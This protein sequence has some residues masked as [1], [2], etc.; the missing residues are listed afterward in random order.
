MT[1]YLT[2]HVDFAFLDEKK[3]S[4]A[5]IVLIWA[6]LYQWNF[7]A[8]N[9]IS[10]A[11][12]TVWRILSWKLPSLLCIG[13]LENWGETTQ[14]VWMTRNKDRKGYL[15]FPLIHFLFCLFFVHLWITLLSYFFIPFPCSCPPS[16]F[17]FPN[18]ALSFIVPFLNLHLESFQMT[19][20][21]LSKLPS[22]RAFKG[23]TWKW[24]GKQGPL[25]SSCEQR[26]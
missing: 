22:F 4:S 10:C 19:C 2:L 24:N 14:Y 13:S 17:S 7:T 16:S 18:V 25:H 11:K 12:C 15:S 9:C 21:F 3:G 1:F 20:F 5:N 23:C 6:H 26:A 8:W